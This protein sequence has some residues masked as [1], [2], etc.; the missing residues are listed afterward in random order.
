MPLSR[1]YSP[2]WS[3]LDTGNVGMDF[4]MLVPPGVGILDGSLQIF[5]NIPNPVPSTDFAMGDFQIRDRTVY[6]QISGGV[7][8]TDYQ[9][10]WFIETTD[11]ARFLRT[12]LLLCAQTS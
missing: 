4:S 9:L 3:P 5:L 1:R 7:E 2:E 6:V 8:G 12:A 10:R 11:G